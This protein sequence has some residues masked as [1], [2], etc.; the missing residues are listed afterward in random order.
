MGQK[1]L[2]YIIS[3]NN[4]SGSIPSAPQGL[5]N[6]KESIEG[7]PFELLNQSMSGIFKNLPQQLQ[8]LVKQMGGL[9]NMGADVQKVLGQIQNGTISADQ[10]VQTFGG[11]TAMTAG[12]SATVPAQLQQA[13]TQL[14]GSAAKKE[15]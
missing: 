9:Q 14:S 5:K 2:D 4:I 1:L 8:Q 12:L 10:I 6:L 7:L 15:D 11:V 13:L 3:K